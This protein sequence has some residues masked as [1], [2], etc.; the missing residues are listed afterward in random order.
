MHAEAQPGCQK[1]VPGVD[2]G[3]FEIKQPLFSLQLTCLD[4]LLAVARCRRGTLL[5]LSTR[6]TQE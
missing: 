2:S 3:W 5:F 1:Q 4:T 6:C